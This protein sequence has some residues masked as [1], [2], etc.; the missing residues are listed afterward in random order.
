MS[1]IATAARD[2]EE[3]PTTAA[4][5]VATPTLS[6]VTLTSLSNKPQGGLSAGDCDTRLSF[7]AR[8]G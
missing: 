3:D 8:T 1:R 7:H 2:P 5:A 6:T 4:T